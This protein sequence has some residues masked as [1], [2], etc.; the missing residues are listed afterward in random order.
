MD[1]T[2]A[3]K[4]SGQAS[5]PRAIRALKS[6]YREHG[7]MLGRFKVGLI[8]ASDFQ[9]WCAGVKVSIA[10]NEKLNMDRRLCDLESKVLGA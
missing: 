1:L 8:S 4:H 7:S 2:T 3:L 5:N 6:V 10:L 9:A